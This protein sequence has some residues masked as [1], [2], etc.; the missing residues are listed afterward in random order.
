MSAVTST[1]ESVP[2]AVREPGEPSMVARARRNLTSRTA[3]FLALLIALLWTVPTFG[4]FVSSIRGR[5][6]IL[7]SGWWMWFRHPE[8]TLDNYRGV[9]TSGGDV[10]LTTFFINSLVI[11][12]PSVLFPL[13]FGAL[14]AYA[15]SWMEWRGR[16]WT[17]VLI[18]ALQIVP[19]QMALL[20]LQLPPFVKFALVTA[21][22]VPVTFLWSH[23]LLKSRAL[24]TVF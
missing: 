19:I 16:D 7:S 14:A 10:N 18:F 5:D 9:L 21:L 23:A 6:S 3:S 12:V 24:R 20:G 8:F 22:A 15:L 4:L 17:F 11:A 1:P 13:A 2:S